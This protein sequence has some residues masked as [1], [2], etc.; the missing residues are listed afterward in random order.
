LSLTARFSSSDTESSYFAA[1][2][3][4]E[5]ELRGLNAAILYSC[6]SKKF[7]FVLF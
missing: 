4:K 5:K 7:P 1:E 3:R 2:E 6:P